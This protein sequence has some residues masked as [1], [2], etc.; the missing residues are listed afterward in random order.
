MRAII[1]IL[2]PLLALTACSSK[3]DGSKGTDVTLNATGKN[4]ESVNASADGN[5]GKIAVNLPGFKA[6]VDMPKIHLDTDDFEMNGAKLYP[7][8]KIASVNV[9]A[10]DAKDGKDNGNVRLAF[11]APADVATVKAWFAKEM[12]E[13]ADFKLTPNTDGLSGANAD[14]D[15]FTLAL[16]PGAANE[17]SGILV[18]TGK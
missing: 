14:G 13:E 1:F 8:S 11:T 15:S 9:T 16:T 6:E 7:G 17:T 18:M 12:T 5:T 3:D 10:R 4:G 2:T